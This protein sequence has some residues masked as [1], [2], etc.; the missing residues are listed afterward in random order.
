MSVLSSGDFSKHSCNESWK[1]KSLKKTKKDN[2]QKKIS[3]QKS[4][5]AENFHIHWIIIWQ[6]KQNKLV[7]S[8]IYMLRLEPYKIMN[9]IIQD[10]VL[11]NSIYLHI[12]TMI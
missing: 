6:R 9:V 5:L 7:G 11:N 3:Q 4:C 8:A 2:R 12:E 1:D 10:C